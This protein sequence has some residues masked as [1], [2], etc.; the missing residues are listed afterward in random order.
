MV[1]LR[2]LVFSHAK[3]LI[4]HGLIYWT[5]SQRTSSLFH[6]KDLTERVKQWILSIL[7]QPESK[8]FEKRQIDELAKIIKKREG[9]NE[10]RKTTGE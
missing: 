9:K 6:C 1:D 3:A 7:S 2:L 8:K 5:I 10:V 4:I